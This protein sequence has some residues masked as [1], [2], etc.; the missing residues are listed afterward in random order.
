[1]KAERSY[2]G[3]NSEHL[4]VRFDDLIN[5][6]AYVNEETAIGFDTRTGLG[7]RF[8]VKSRAKLSQN[9]PQSPRY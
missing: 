7:V 6:Y 8:S 4:L 5:V 1:M 2:T 3:A 9:P